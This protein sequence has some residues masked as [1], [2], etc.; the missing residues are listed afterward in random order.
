MRWPEGG[1][2]PTRLGRLRRRFGFDRNEMRRR[3]DRVQWTV[4]VTLVLVFLLAAPALAV[5][6]GARAYDAGV[7]AERRQ[8]ATRW[9]A[10]A[11]VTGPG[12][13]SGERYLHRTVQATWR[14]PNGAVRSGRIP[15][16]KDAEVGARRQ[17]WVDRSGR[18]VARPRPHSRT[19]VDAGYAA[20]GGTA[21]VG[22]PLLFV[23]WLV[24]RRCDRI[25]Y[26]QW[27][28]EWARIDPHRIS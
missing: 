12:G 15:A 8:H 17:I 18:P 16:W 7:R 11:T 22:A 27:D 13:V 6:A 4:G 14:A 25:R 9:E 19:L 10:T 26:A 20:V 1:G 23:Y 28:A 24:R 5:W 3:V 2:A 21:G